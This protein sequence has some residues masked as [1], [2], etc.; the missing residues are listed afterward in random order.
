LLTRCLPEHYDALWIFQKVI[1]PLLAL[2]LSLKTGCSMV[3]HKGADKNTPF[4]LW[5]LKNIA[6]LILI[7]PAAGILLSLKNE[8]LKG[9]A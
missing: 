6:I 8:E 4:V 2:L 1:L 7:N 3:F 5:R 9:V